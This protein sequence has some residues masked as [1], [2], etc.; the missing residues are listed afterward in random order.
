V[1]KPRDMTSVD[2]LR[3]LKR[4]TGPV[5]MGHTGTL[6]PLATGVL[7]V[8]LGEATKL[9]NFMELEPKR[10]RGTL[11]FGLVTD[12]WDITGN[13]IEQRSFATES[14]QILSQAFARQVGERLLPPPIYSAIK[15]KGKPLYTYARQGKQVTAVP[16][17]TVVREFTLLENRGTDLEF[18]LLCNRGTY[19]RS[20]VYALGEDL[21][22]GACLVSL[23]RIRCGRFSIDHALSLDRMEEMLEA[24]RGAD[25]LLSPEQVLG[26]LASYTV[27]GEN[28]KRIKHGNV[29]RDN[30]MERMD[31]RDDR[32]GEK[33][34]VLARGQAIA[35]GEIRKDE[36][37][38]LLQPVRVL[39][40]G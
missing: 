24:G 12:T 33:I 22:C 37:G 16:R 34:L 35:I 5:R 2:V 17:K 20:V 38:Y 32:I 9:L 1:D 14:A 39:N 25:A 26:H 3:R 36:I 4:K 7:P 10:Y 11:R 19:V 8:C 23:R 40:R 15:Y 13:V 21:G 30:G 31:L 18:E 27:E 29:L 6:D 28:E